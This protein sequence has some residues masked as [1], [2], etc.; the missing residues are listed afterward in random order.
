MRLQ[1]FKH[2]KK[3]FFGDARCGDVV[4]YLK[5]RQWV[6]V[7]LNDYRSLHPI[8]CPH[9]M[10]TL[11]PYES[12]PERFH[13]RAELIKRHIRE[14]LHLAAMWTGATIL[15]K[16]RLLDM[17]SLNIGFPAS[18]ASGG[19]VIVRVPI[20]HPCSCKSFSKV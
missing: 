3:I 16:E 5:F 6:D 9:L 10:S 18:T 1:I 14:L 17:S 7:R 2:I 15:S 8:L 13:G 20:F 12:K 4:P 11:N 19:G